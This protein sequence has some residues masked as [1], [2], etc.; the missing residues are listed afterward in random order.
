MDVS[1]GFDTAFS[2]LNP[3][4]RGC[5]SFYIEHGDLGGVIEGSRVGDRG[6]D[7]VSDEIGWDGD[8]L[9]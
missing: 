4:C 8:Q 5:F 6:M 2:L 1:P 7:G 9:S 3:F